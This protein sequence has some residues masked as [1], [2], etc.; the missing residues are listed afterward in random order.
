MFFSCYTSQTPSII[1]KDPSAY[2]SKPQ[3]S[4]PPTSLKGL[5]P[6]IHLFV[7]PNGFYALPL[8]PTISP[9]WQ[10]KILREVFTWSR[11]FTQLMLPLSLYTR[12]SPTLILSSLLFFLLCHFGYVICFLKVNNPSLLNWHFRCL[13]NCIYSTLT[14]FHFIFFCLELPRNLRYIFSSKWLLHSLAKVPHA[15]SSCS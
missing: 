2:I 7:N 15:L 4:L 8:Y 5:K 6:I 12:W 14:L 13:N 1:F 9:Y 3:Y 11:T 10:S